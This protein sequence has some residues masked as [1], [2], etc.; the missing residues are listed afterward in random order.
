[1]YPHI[2]HLNHANYLTQLLI[3]YRIVKK[4]GLRAVQVIHDREQKRE[5]QRQRRNRAFDWAKER[6]VVSK[7]SRERGCSVPSKR[8]NSHPRN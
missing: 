2:F 7:V 3:N 5:R 6:A 1:M 4:R 8:R